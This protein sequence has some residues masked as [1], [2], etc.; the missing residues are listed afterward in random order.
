M[1]VLSGV[2]QA[3]AEAALMLQVEGNAGVYGRGV[4]V[5]ADSAGAGRIGV[6]DLVDGLQLIY[7]VDVAAGNAVHGAD[8]LHVD[9]GGAGEAV[10]T[11][12]VL[13]LRLVTF[14]VVIVVDVH[15]PLRH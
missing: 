10:E 3:A 4:N 12:D 7:R 9:L 2:T 13:V 6:L 5:Q 14:Q 15:S 8:A 11:D 1:A